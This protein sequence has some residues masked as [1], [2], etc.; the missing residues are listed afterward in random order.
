MRLIK[1]NTLL[2]CGCCG[3]AFATWNKYIDQ[4]Q[5]NGYGICESCQDGIADHD[6]KE[7]DKAIK[8]LKDG[9]KEEN[10][11]KFDKLDR[12]FQEYFVY[13]AM[14]EGVLVQNLTRS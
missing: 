6:N 13:K 11:V 1:K 9:L 14:E 4:D 12:D 10:R 7:M 8:V 5:D 2:H 3:E